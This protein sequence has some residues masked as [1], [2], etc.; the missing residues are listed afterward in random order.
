M[1]RKH[2]N[3]GVTSWMFV[4]EKPGSSREKRDRLRKFG[5]ATKKEAEAA[6]AAARMSSR[7]LS[8]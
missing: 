8:A 5:F 6:E 7:R 4:I 3:R 2:T 1:V